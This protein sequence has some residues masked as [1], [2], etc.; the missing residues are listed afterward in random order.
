M[1]ACVELRLPSRP[2]FV[3]VARLTVAG[4]AS[5]MSFDVEAIEDIK[6]AVSEA[7][8][9]AIEHGCPSADCSAES[10]FLCCELEEDVLVI[11]VQ[12]PGIGF[13]PIISPPPTGGGTVIDPPLTEGG[14]GLLLI[15]ALMDEVTISSRPEDGTRVRMVKRLRASTVEER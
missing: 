1:P 15:E 8:T 14:L 10:I 4:V 6:V 9:N 12:D 11:T 3:G 7:C 2:E 13:E 5:R